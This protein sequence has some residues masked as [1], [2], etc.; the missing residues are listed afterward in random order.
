MVWGRRGFHPADVFLGKVSCA[1]C[2]AGS[3][4]V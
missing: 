1:L 4:G 2:E 3:V